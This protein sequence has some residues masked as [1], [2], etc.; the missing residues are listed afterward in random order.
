[1]KVSAI[2][3][4]QKLTGNTDAA[5]QVLVEKAKEVG[6]DALGGAEILC[7]NLK[8]SYKIRTQKLKTRYFS[9]FLTSWWRRRELNPCPKIICRGFLRVQSVF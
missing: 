3:A 7:E 6:L 2:K 1:M 5:Q 9:G 4:K 8:K